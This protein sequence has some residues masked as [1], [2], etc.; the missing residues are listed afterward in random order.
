MR[1]VHVIVVAAVAGTI[2]VVA[3]SESDNP[4]SPTKVTPVVAAAV[5]PCIGVNSTGNPNDPTV[6]NENRVFLEAQGW[7]GERRADLTVPRFGDAEH[8]HVGMCFPLQQTVSGTLPFRV[9]VLG[10]NLRTNSIIKSTNLHDPDGGTF[11]KI[12]WNHTIGSPGDVT[13]FQDVNVNTA[14]AGH[15]SGRRE[16]RVLTIVKRPDGAEIHSSSG[17]CWTVANGGGIVNSGTCDATP[18]STMGRGWYSCFEYKI[19]EVRNWTYPYAGIPANAN[20]QVSIGARDGAS[21]PPLNNTLLNSWTVRLNPSFHA[22]NLGADLKSGTAPAYGVNVTIPP[23]PSGSLQKLV[24]VASANGTCSSP[25][26]PTE[27]G[28]VSAV[29]VIPIKVQ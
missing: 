1:Y 26:I 8:I 25:G 18:L 29:Q 4:S 20:Y 17:W 14:L 16:F 27:R 19:A 5:V 28:E 9:I 3:C 13:L 2:A 10:H 11:K 7:W 23:K 21:E 12:D 6:Y 15:E 24:V 22:G